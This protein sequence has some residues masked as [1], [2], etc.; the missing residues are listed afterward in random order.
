MK[1]IVIGHGMV[2]HKLLECLAQTG[3]ADLDVTV[4]CEEPRPAYDRVHLS[5]FFAGKS[6]DDLSLVEAGFFERENFLLKLNAKAVSI[7]RAARTVTASTGETLAY[8]KLVLATG[9]YPFVPPLPGRD[10][11]DCFV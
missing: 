1:L 5:E 10:R 2:G 4:L 7:D 8:D 3:A 11:P 9:S 6:A